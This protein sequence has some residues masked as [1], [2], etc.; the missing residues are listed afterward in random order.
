MRSAAFLPV[1]APEPRVERLADV[2]RRAMASLGEHMLARDLE[3]AFGAVVL[4]LSVRH[5]AE[6]EHAV[7]VATARFASTLGELNFSLRR[8]PGLG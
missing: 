1:V 7:H 4:A 8:V 3:E 5:L 6:P 2:V